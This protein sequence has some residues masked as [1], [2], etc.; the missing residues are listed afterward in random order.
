MTS[1]GLPPTSGPPT[2]LRS[3]PD[4]VSLTQ[5]IREKPGRSDTWCIENIVVLCSATA[6]GTLFLGLPVQPPPLGRDRERGVFSGL[7]MPMFD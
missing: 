1:L 4:L 6:D 3:R 5:S 7:L 2:P